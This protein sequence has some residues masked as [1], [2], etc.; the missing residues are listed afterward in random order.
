MG[1][2]VGR[3]GPGG[4]RSHGFSSSPP[5][6]GRCHGR[7]RAR[8]GSSGERN[9]R[10]WGRKK[11][12]PL[13]PKVGL[14]VTLVKVGLLSAGAHVSRRFVLL[15]LRSSLYRYC[16]GYNYWSHPPRRGRVTS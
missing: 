1:R 9:V 14:R 15:P 6:P 11:M 4:R 3:C 10:P 12:A 2:V 13:V 7:A 5:S 8:R 16:W